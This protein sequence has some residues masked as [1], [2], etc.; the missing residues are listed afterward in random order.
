MA[1]A[2]YT[3]AFRGLRAEMLFSAQKQRGSPH[4]PAKQRGYLKLS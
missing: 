2:E 4:Q 1:A 3:L